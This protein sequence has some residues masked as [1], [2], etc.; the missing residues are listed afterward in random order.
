MNEK[1]D[2][3]MDVTHSSIPWYFVKSKI[4]SLNQI[5]KFASIRLKS[6]SLVCFGVAL[7]RLLSVG[8]HRV[9]EML[10]FYVIFAR[11][12]N[13]C[14]FFFAGKFKSPNFWKFFVCCPV[15]LRVVAR[16]LFC[17]PGFESPFIHLNFHSCGY[18]TRTSSNP[19][20]VDY[21]LLTRRQ[22]TV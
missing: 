19:A 16:R 1:K 21:A 17:W 14:M 15:A 12:L 10:C 5:F 7:S 4:N 13:F 2:L 20:W 11:I 18:W 3:L 9:C 8:L 22:Q 6:L